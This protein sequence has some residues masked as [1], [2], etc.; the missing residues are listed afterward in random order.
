VA[1]VAVSCALDIA[2]EGPVRVSGA[3]DVARLDL[4]ALAAAQVGHS[5]PSKSP[6]K[7][8]ARNGATKSGA[9]KGWPAEPFGRP[10]WRSRST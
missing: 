4:P 7:S 6:S 9:A 8:P 10:W 3:L 1:G 5:A 2:A